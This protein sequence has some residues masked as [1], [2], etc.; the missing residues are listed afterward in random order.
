MNCLNVTLDR[1]YYLLIYN[2]LESVKLNIDY[3]QK[4]LKLNLWIWK[5]VS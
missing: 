1:R 2:W 4:N 5:D 3:A